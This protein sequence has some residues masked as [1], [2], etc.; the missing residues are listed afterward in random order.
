MGAGETPSLFPGKL[1]PFSSSSVLSPSL[2]CL[3]LTLSFLSISVYIV[4]HS[5]SLSPNFPLALLFSVYHPTSLSS[6]SV[7]RLLPLAF[8]SFLC[9]SP[10][11]LICSLS[12]YISLRLSSD[13]FLCPFLYHPTSLSLCPTFLLG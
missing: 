1:S 9:V 12:P 8:S 3:S 5:P 2:F 11:F 7:S 6:L 10:P 4:S 13:F